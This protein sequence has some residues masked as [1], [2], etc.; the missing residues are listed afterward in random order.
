MRLTLPLSLRFIAGLATVAVLAW[1]A[2]CAGLYVFQRS[3]IFHGG[4]T[5]P[6]VPPGVEVRSLATADGL[7]LNAW[8]LPPA[9]A[10]RPVIL[11]LH[12]NSGH[13]GHRAGR[14]PEFAAAGWGMLMVEYRGFGGNPGA[15]SEEG[16]ALDAA[17][18][19]AALTGMGI[20][21]ARI[22][23]WGESLGTAV[24]IRLA[25][26]RPAAALLLE[27]PFTS[28]ADMAR[29]RYP[30]VPVDALLKDRF[31][32]LGRIGALAM[33]ILIVNGALDSI[34]PPAMGQRLH[35][36]ATAPVHEFHPIAAAGHNDL[37]GFG[38]VG[39]GMDFLRRH[40]TLR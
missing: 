28:M 26:E 21:P 8:Y 11:F 17:A 10:D 2:L 38:V 30:F 13:I 18:A 24:A 12:G 34:V 14:L 5:R 4:A 15:P 22:V 31:E 40:L 3:F 1:L 36:A 37:P 6:D 23:I 39:I 29:H 7:A 25:S 9:A 32:S 20:A 16:L 35:Q 33:P 19:H 27:A